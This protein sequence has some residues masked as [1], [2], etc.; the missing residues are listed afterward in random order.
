MKKLIALCLLFCISVCP[1]FPIDANKIV[2]KENGNDR[3][4]S[5]KDAQREAEIKTKAG[6]LGLGSEIKVVM[7][8]SVNRSHPVTH[9]GTID[10]I[11]N[12]GIVIQA[13]DKTTRLG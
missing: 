7:R 11:C 2:L 12:E 4:K 1:A 5:D 13:G 8:H 10:E 9:R 6:L 3:K